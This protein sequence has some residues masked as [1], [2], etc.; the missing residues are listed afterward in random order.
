[1]DDAL[2][3]VGVITAVYLLVLWDLVRRMYDD[4]GDV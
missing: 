1:V 4:S 3:A 2:F